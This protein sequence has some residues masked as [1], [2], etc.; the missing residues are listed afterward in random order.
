MLIYAHFV[1]EDVSRANTSMVIICVWHHAASAKPA[2]A[3]GD[4]REV[5]GIFTV[6]IFGGESY[7]INIE[8]YIAIKCITT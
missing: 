4:A 1:G 6:Y 2:G 3:V 8:T 7:Y 5:M